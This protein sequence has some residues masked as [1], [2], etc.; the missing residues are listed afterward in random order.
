MAYQKLQEFRAGLWR[1][2]SAQHGVITRAQLL[3]LGF[4]PPAIHH[5]VSKGRL[6][7]VQRGVYAIGRP[8]LTRN[9]VWMAAVLSCGPRAVLS[10]KSAGALWGIWLKE[11]DQ[12][13]VSVP[14]GTFRQRPGLVVH[15]R[16]AL[17][18]THCEG[19]PVTTAVQ[20]LADLA[21]CLERDQVEF[22][23]N[24]GG[25]AWA[26]RSRVGSVGPGPP[27]RSLGSTS[28]A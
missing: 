8:Q 1:I 28:V 11:G 27:A 6:H 16:S 25:Q 17:R 10:H 5:R 23:I 14:A 7:P 24:Q 18:S 12:I 20:T 22:A 4:T 26:S 21:T 9:G 2:A 15:R 3:A 13:E 19:I